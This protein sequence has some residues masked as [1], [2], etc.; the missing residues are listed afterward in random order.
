MVA[1]V[2]REAA[3]AYFAGKRFGFLIFDERS[4]RRRM[5][6]FIP[7]R[8]EWVNRVVA[9]SCRW[10]ADFHNA[11]KADAAVRRHDFCLRGL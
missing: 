5:R 4:P 7:G 2:R 6:P 1:A 9:G 3:P 8:S 11:P 10:S